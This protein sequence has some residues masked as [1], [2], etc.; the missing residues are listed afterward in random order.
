MKATPRERETVLDL[1]K[2]KVT[3]ALKLRNLQTI[4]FFLIYFP[5]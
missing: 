2:G 5:L 1:L 4:E 3:F